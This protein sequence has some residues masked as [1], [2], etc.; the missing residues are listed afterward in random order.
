MMGG[1][2]LSIGTYGLLALRNLWRNPRRTGLTLAAFIVGVG[3]LTF[4]VALDDGWLESM[5]T[6]FIHSKT[7]HVQIHAKGFE[8]E[9]KVQNH[10]ADPAPILRAIRGDS[11]IAET[12][13]RVRSSGLASVAGGSAGVDIIGVQP[14]A[15]ARLSRLAKFVA[16]GRWLKPGEKRGLL[17]GKTIAE[18]LRAE[19]GDKVVLMAQAPNGDLVSEVFRLR[20]ILYSGTPAVDQ[21]LANA[22]IQTVQKWLG[23]ES[24]VTDIVIRAVNH[25]V[26]AGLHQEMREKLMGGV[27]GELEVMSWIDIDPMIQQWTE[28]VDAATYFILMI[29]LAVVLVEVLNTMLMSMHERVREFGLM[30]AV[31]TGKRQIFAMMLWETVVLVMLGGLTGYAVG[32]MISL[33]F[34]AA[35]I[36]LTEF[37][38]AFTFIYMDPIVYP[39]VKVSSGIKIIS[40][41]LFSALLA[42]LY[43]AWKATRLDPVTAMREV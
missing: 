8:A 20:G 37:A 21:V 31:G 3:A 28:M 4:L 42:G 11:R 19:L 12:A 9:R 13:L 36:N 10:I 34:G 33:H 22:P 41:T 38:E 18:K 15:E 35:G 7:G 1:S 6:N 26:S 27:F 17:L 39:I 2:R 40:V 23:L 16:E 14:E 30:E 24:G 43:P 32:V 29:V 5:K 25:E